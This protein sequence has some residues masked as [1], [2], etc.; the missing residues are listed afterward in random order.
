MRTDDRSRKTIGA[1]EASPAEVVGIVSGMAS[2]TV[3]APRNLPTKLVNKLGDAAAQH[4]GTVQ[5]HG[6]MFAQWMLHAFP[7]ECPFPHVSG[8][9]TPVTP[10]EWLDSKGNDGYAPLEEMLH[11]TQRA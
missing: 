6:R 1:L 10:D 11:Y 9:I 4:G 7:R 8:S 3:E 5:I 2:S